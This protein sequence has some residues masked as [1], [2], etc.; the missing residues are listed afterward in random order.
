[1]LELLRAMYNKPII[2]SSGYR[3]GSH[4]LAVSNSGF[5]GPHTIGAVDITISG[6]DAYDLTRAACLL[7]F[8]GIGIKQK[9]PHEVRFIHL[10]NCTIPGDRIPRP[11][12]WSY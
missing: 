11:M 2:I 8:S 4:N 9:W 3:C 10:D 1:M 5:D 12:I 7:G 6:Q